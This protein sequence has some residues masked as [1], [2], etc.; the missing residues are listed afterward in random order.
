M[1][2]EPVEKFSMTTKNIAKV[3]ATVSVIAM[4]MSLSAVAQKG[5]WALADDPV[6][7]EM[8]VMERM[9]ANSACSPQPGLKEVIA[10][11]FQ[12]TAPNGNRYGKADAIETDLK[13][14]QR[15]CQLG[16][17]K[18][19]F[20]GEMLAVAYGNESRIRK[21]K[22]GKD[23]M[24]CLAWTDTWLKRDGKW[25]IIAAQDGVVECKK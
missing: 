22:N 15:Q 13:N 3:I 6:A 7:K 1:H 11:E 17:V 18:I 25:Q 4:M 23:T 16:D 21:D 5:R 10:D 20:F 9:W 19:Q 14:P 12:G 2:K 24:L 8:I